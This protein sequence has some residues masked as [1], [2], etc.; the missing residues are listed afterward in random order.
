MIIFPEDA[1]FKKVDTGRQ[2]DRVYLLQYKSSSR[3]FFFWMQDAKSDKDDQN[4]TKVHDYMNNP[5]QP[6]V[7]T[8]QAGGPNGQLDQN[9]LMQ[10]LGAFGGGQGEG[11]APTNVQMSDLQNILQNMG[12]PPTSSSSTAP[13]G[14]TAGAATTTT[15]GT[16]TSAVPSGPAA[17][18][19]AQGEEEESEEAMLQRALEESLKD[20]NSGDANAGNGRND[21]MDTA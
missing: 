8:G 17:T 14:T 1:S 9:M 19:S 21:G 4:A 16:T 20:D 15:P 3:R 7:P 10:M 6:N 2:G 12:V 13:S 5:P 11:G 18:S